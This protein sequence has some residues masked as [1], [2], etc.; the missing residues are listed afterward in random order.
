MRPNTKAELEFLIRANNYLAPFSA[1]WR[2]S[3]IMLVIW[4]LSKKSVLANPEGGS[5]SRVENAKLSED[6]SY[7]SSMGPV[8]WDKESESQAKAHAREVEMGISI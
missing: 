2:Q 4:K 5:F 8:E 3:C 6:A 7:F 1:I